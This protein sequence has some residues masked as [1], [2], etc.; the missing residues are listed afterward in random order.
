MSIEYLCACGR[1]LNAPERASGRRARCPTCGA[2]AVIPMTSTVAPIVPA[3]VAPAIS[4]A[5]AAASLPPSDPYMYDLAEPEPRPAPRT[6]APRVVVPLAPALA[7]RKPPRSRRIGYAYCLLLLAILPLVLFTFMS[8]TDFKE[9]LLQTV[10]A[11]PEMPDLPDKVVSAL[12]RAENGE[13]TE[14]DFFDV[15]PDHRLD[16]ALLS[17]DSEMHWPLALGAAALWMGLLLAL[18]PAARRF[19]LSVGISALFTATCGVLLLLAFQFIA[20]HMPVGGLRFGKLGLILLIIKLIGYSYAIADSDYGFFIS[21]L[22]YTCGVGLCEEITKAIPLLWRV[23]GPG[24]PPKWDELLVLG[25]ASGIGFGIA[26]GIMYAGHY[27]NG[28][29]GG[30]MYLVRFLSCVVLHAFWA[31]AVAITLYNHQDWLHDAENNW[32]YCFNVARIVLIPMCLHGLYDTLLKQDHNAW[33]LLVAA[34][35]FAW[36]L[37]QVE[38]MKRTEPDPAV[39]LAA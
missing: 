26:E 34:T 39:G 2:I 31:G 15:L 22:G 12:D 16:D 4:A 9:R 19:G 20:F 11:H 23:K 37:Y 36:F 17:R 28:L 8:H 18:F 1:Q 29:E 13:G 25:L 27:Y 33:A 32:M 5:P 7:I 38:R 21:F 10:K 3:S 30:G 14:Q 24:E 6:A 35:S